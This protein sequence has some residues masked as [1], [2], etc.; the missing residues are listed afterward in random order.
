M[1]KKVD[2][3]V[4]ALI[5][6]C[7]ATNHRSLFVV[8]GDKGRHQV[9]NLHYILSK[10][11]VKARPSVLWCYKKELG[12][13]SHKQKRI[14]QLKKMAHRAG[15][16]LEKMQEDP[17]ELFISATN[18]RYCYYSESHKVLG[19]TFGMC[20]LQDFEALT[21]NLLART[22]ETVEGGGIVLILLKT[23]DSL[24]QLY[25]MTMDV[26]NRF[27]TE[28]HKDVVARFNERFLLSLGQCQS[29]L[30]VDD[31]LNVLPISSAAKN[32]LSTH[33][34]SEVQPDPHA[35][36]LKEL[37]ESLRETQPIGNLVA[38]AKTI[39]QAKCLLTFMEAVSDKTLRSTVAMTAGRG[40]GKSAALGMS[41]AGAIAYGYSNIFVTSP[42][43]ENLNT[44][45][46]FVL[47]V[48][49]RVKLSIKKEGICTKVE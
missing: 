40:R 1:K 38:L 11:T 33:Q 13:S 14:K 42:S 22:I 31:E 45:F 36:E 18:I 49:S 25:T 27:R 47:K 30:V 21:P 7:V 8:V 48:K 5:E 29:A 17:F 2:Q 26:H 43:P 24:K 10:A 32:F 41:I 12:F 23:M 37:C 3:R 39:D 6:A 16:D 34:P 44:L 46:E 20:V 19:N 9:V 15:T 4:R 35:V 28:A